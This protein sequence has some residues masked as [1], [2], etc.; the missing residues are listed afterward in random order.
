[1]RVSFS[2]G[3]MS[4]KLI[5]KMSK[6]ADN[7]EFKA[8]DSIQEMVRDSTLRHIFFDRIVFSEKILN[9]PEKDFKCLNDY[10]SEYS[11]NTTIVFICQKT[12]MKNERLFSEIFNSPLYTPVLVGNV[13]VKVLLEFVKSDINELRVKYYS[14]DVKK[15]NP[16][17]VDVDKST[18][19]KPVK[20]G[21][22][23]SLF[24]GKK[25]SA[26]KFE[27][28]NADS[29]DVSNEGKAEET[30]PNQGFGLPSGSFVS[31]GGFSSVV[32]MTGNMVEKGLEKNLDS[33]ESSRG[34]GG[35]GDFNDINFEKNDEV[36]SL[37]IG[38]L[39]E[40]HI[41]TGFLDD[42]AESEIEQEL[43]SLEQSQSV[44]VDSEENLERVDYIPS[45]S[46]DLG[47]AK[48]NLL[49]GDRNTGLTTT[50]VDNSVSLA[51]E[52][53]K[54]LIVDLDY[55]TNGIL[56][57]IDTEKYYKESKCRGI[58]KLRIYSEDGVDVISNGY[59]VSIE[60]SS[61]VALYKSNLFEK[62]DFVFLDCPLDCLN[63]LSSSIISMSSINITVEGNRGAIISLFS[64]LS[65]S[66]LVTPSLEDSLFD[67]SKLVVINKIDEYQDEV[68][69]IKDL[70]LFGREDWSS[71]LI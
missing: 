14:L 8:Y 38:D 59:G 64:S 41:D 48:V 23:N 5:D 1:M 51:D 71:K 24:G 10:I 40:M 36:D 31:D 35:V 22:F 44:D 55:K 52:G 46:F 2:L 60:T 3:A 62:Y 20:K 34:L 63:I 25:N 57:F 32:G 45:S 17:Q 42:D 39:G 19:E 65:D 29:D 68:A 4:G 7:I 54:V 33:N 58:D 47:T 37:G 66:T 6:S 12:S 27:K 69:F 26:E 13:T 61:L 9:N 50:I 56:S 53:K 30:S 49:I 43:E 21:F 18:A 70:C 15:D 11:D 28:E 16:A 67:N